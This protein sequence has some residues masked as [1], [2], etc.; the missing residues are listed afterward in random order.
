MKKC[1]AEINKALAENAVVR[2]HAQDTSL[3]KYDKQRLATF[4]NTPGSTAQ[5][6][7]AKKRLPLKESDCDNIGDFQALCHK[8]QNWDKN[9][10]F[11][12]SALAME[13]RIRRKDADHKIKLL[14]IELGADIPEKK[15]ISKQKRSLK[16]YEDSDISMPALPTSKKLKLQEKELIET[17]VISIGSPCCPL[18]VTYYKKGVKYEKTAMGRKYSLSEIRQKLTDKH[19]PLMRLNSHSE[20]NEMSRKDI[21]ELISKVAPSAL[22]EFESK[23]VHTM[24]TLLTMCQRNRSMWVWSDHS[25]LLGYGLVVIVVGVVYDPLVYLTDEEVARSSKSTMSVQEIVE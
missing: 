17:N 12:G 20:I 14:A 10:Q 21:L 24:R 15:I 11:V 2:V 4:Y 22:P 23:E 8:L 7:K 16:K 19:R 18:P 13:F 5:P 6:T 3:S 1:T 9:E 25:V